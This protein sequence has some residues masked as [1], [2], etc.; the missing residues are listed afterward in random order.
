MTE[1]KRTHT[2]GRCIYYYNFYC[3]L[4]NIQISYSSKTC[5]KFR[6]KWL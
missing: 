6:E 4:K 3:P 5:N 2:C 1:N